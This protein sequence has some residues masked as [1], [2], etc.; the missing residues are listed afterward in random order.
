M[1]MLLLWPHKPRAA[2]ETAV[3]PAQNIE[4]PF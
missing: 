3:F 4:L 1:L 2:N